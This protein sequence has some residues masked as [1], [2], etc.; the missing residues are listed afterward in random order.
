MLADVVRDAFRITRRRPGPVLIDVCKDVTAAVLSTRLKARRTKEADIGV[1]ESKIGAV[2]VINEAKTC[3]TFRR[4]GF[5]IRANEELVKFTKNKIPVTT[6]LMG[7]GLP[8]TNDLFMGMIGMHGTKTTNL[9]YLNRIFYCN[10]ARFSDKVI[11]MLKD[12][13]LMLK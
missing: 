4:R 7:M 6:T 11:V 5:Y 9:Q 10:S 1:K 3:Y 2:R 13:H 8:G 12:L